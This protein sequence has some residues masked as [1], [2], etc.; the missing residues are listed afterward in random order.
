MRCFSGE[1]GENKFNVVPHALGD[2]IWEVK[3]SMGDIGGHR[4]FFLIF[5]GS[6]G[7]FVVARFVAFFVVKL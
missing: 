7:G 2:H 3:K 5:L 4:T 6:F 1:G